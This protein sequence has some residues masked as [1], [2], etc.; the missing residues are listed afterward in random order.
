MSTIE[1]V[2][3]PSRLR[4]R[5]EF[6]LFFLVAPLAMAF[7]IPPDRMF[8][9]LFALT[10]TGAA[11]LHLTRSFA[12]RDLR[13]GW[14]RILWGRVA[15]IGV[16]TLLFGVAW[17]W[18]F[19]P[20]ALFQIAR[21]RPDMM[22]MILVLY[23]LISALPQEIVYR[24]LFFRR[25]QPVLPRTPGAAIVL[26]AALFSLAHL[27]YW[28]WLVLAMTFVGGLA[29]AW[30]YEIRRSFPMAVLMH[31]LAGDAIFLAGLGV[32]FYSGNVVRPF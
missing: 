5:V 15:G 8:P 25:Y 23:P 4:L 20:G 22:L 16:A 31:A 28:S 26:N 19:R 7:L 21:Q 14:G 9:M 18:L 12:W 30:A 2:R 3:Q 1:L 11:L 6:G 17:L 27:M 10:L 32:Y 13:N 24:A 29:F